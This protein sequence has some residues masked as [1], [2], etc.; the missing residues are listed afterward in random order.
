MIRVAGLAVL[1]AV[2]GSGDASQ[3]SRLKIVRGI[4]YE[5]E[6]SFKL[7]CSLVWVGDFW[8]RLGFWAY[9]VEL[10]QSATVTGCSKR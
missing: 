9:D 7:G 5:N 2:V 1:T 10:F 3:E 4:N 8:G 6:E